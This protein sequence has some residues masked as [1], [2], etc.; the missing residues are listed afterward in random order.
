[1][2]SVDH[3]QAHTTVGRT[4]LDEGSARRR[5]LYLTTQTLTRNKHP[6]PG[7]IR[8]DDPSKR[9]AANLSLRPCGHWDWNIMLYSVERRE[10]LR[11]INQ[12]MCMCKEAKDRQCTYKRN[13][14]ARSHNHFCRGKAISTSITH[15]ESGFVTLDLQHAMRMHRIIL[16]SV[17]R[18]LYHIFPHYIINGTII[19]RKLLNTKCVF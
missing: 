18:R 3:T 19:G 13:I 2:I 11:K 7:G 17:V 10:S 16:S 8:T 14:K 5:D 1:V 4:P 9:S 12:S 6:Y 15:S